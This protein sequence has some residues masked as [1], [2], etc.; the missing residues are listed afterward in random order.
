ML[1]W[2]DG[3]NQRGVGVRMETIW[4]PKTYTDPNTR[5]ENFVRVT[6]SVALTKPRN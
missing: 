4:L 2:G 6:F 3:V 5:V 1:R